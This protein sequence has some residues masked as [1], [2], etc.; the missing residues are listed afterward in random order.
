MCDTVLAESRLLLSEQRDR[1]LESQ[2]LQDHTEQSWR[3][4]FKTPVRAENQHTV[5]NNLL[6]HTVIADNTAGV[7]YL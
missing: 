4:I 3:S 2:L 5:L 7:A 6:L 1:A